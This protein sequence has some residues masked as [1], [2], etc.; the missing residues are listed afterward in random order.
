M[1]FHLFFQE[2]LDVK[3]INRTSIAQPYSGVLSGY[4]Q[5]LQI[6]RLSMTAQIHL[7]F[8]KLRFLCFFHLFFQENLDVKKMVELQLLNPIVECFQG[9][10]RGCKSGVQV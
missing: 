2:N 3:K 6:W 9:T 4:L 1:I 7:I 10:F 8:E 5:G